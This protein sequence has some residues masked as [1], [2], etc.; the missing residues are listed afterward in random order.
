MTLKKIAIIPARAG[1]KG[2]PNKNI[3][4]L[5][6]K[7]LMAYSIEAAINSGCFERVIVSTDSLEYKTIAEQYGAEVILRD[8]ELA[9]DSATSFMVIE[10]VLNKVVGYDY[11]VLLQPTSPFRNAEHIQQATEQFELQSQMNFL[12]SV[13]ESHK[14]ADLIKPI[15]EDLSLK[16]FDLDFSNYRRQNSKEYTPNGAIFIGRNQAYLNKKHFFGA[17]SLAFIMNKA[18]SV[19]IDDKLDFELAIFLQIQKNKKQILFNTIHNRIAEKQEKMKL[20]TDITLIGHSIF[21]YW[22]IEILNNKTVNNLGIAGISSKEYIDFI[23]N[24]NLL[25]EVGNTVLLFAGTNDLVIEGWQPQDSVSW[26]TK[27][28]QYLMRLNHNVQ[29][30]LLSVPPV[31]G[32]IDR[33]NTTIKSLNQSLKKLSTEISQL[34]WI[35]LSPSFYDEFGN[36]PANFTY[37]GLHFSKEAYQQLELELS[38]KL[39]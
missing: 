23:L 6:D 15:D 1:S 28:S 8:E 9:S 17:D 4:M 35:E 13:C 16:H 27:I 10:D 19:D 5:L 18:D 22:N 33:S 2:L 7:P 39:S 25:G 34:E 26:V 14:S 21:D 12:A 3:L 29:I 37:D 36:L 32:R 38:Q 11:F 30:K 31:R 20:S 24:R